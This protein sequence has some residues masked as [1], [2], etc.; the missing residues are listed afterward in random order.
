VDKL[1]KYFALFLSVI[2]A[3]SGLTVSFPAN[4]Q[5]VQT[6]PASAIAPW[7]VLQRIDALK[8]SSRVGLSG[9]TTTSAPKNRLALGFFLQPKS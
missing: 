8:F 6:I 9:E 1:K 2:L 3:I 4:A 7:P 5:A